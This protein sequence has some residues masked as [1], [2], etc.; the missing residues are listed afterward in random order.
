MRFDRLNITVDY[1]K[2][3]IGESNK[4]IYIQVGFN[5]FAIGIISEEEDHI[6]LVAE[7]DATNPRLAN[8]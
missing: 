8:D 6:L 2:D 1:I 4:P 7:E 3:L 5:R